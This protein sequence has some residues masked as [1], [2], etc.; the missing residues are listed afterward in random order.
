MIVDHAPKVVD[1]KDTIV[2]AIGLLT[3]IEGLLN[4]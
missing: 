4:P 1:D 3:T 2:M